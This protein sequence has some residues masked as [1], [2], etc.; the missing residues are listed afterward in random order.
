MKYF[1]LMLFPVFGFANPS[2][3]TPFPIFL[4][5]GFSTVLDF[6][7]APSKVV[8]G[9]TQTF[10]IEKLGKS[11]V[12][13]TLV[14]FA[15]T[16]LFVYFKQREPKVYLLTASEEAEPTYYKKFSEV[17]PP[18]PAPVKSPPARVSKVSQRGAQLVSAKFDSKKDY[19]TI[20]ILI[21][22]D[23]KGTI[24][25]AWNLVRLMKGNIALAPRKLW[26]E[27]R[28]I[29]RDSRATARFIFAKPNISRD[30]KTSLI[31]VPL[32]GEAA[33][34]KVNL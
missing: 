8:L 16:N 3:M 32:L 1:L 34:F 11:L 24:R 10:Q 21:S 22:A 6:D 13:K 17:V 29:Q 25:P 2:L 28:D 18:K 5:A 26:A 27:R 33:P 30:L 20:E 4:R 14:P 31:V 7:E 19:L 15:T 23:S 12:I 9:D